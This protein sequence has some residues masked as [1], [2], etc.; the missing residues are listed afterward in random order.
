MSSGDSTIVSDNGPC[1]VS[2]EIKLFNKMN[3]IHHIKVSPHRPA[4][5]G[6]ADLQ[7]RL[8]KVVLARWETETNNLK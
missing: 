5:N 7:S 1:F 8:S 3:G 2:S 4:S 6:L